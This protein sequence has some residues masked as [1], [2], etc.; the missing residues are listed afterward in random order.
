MRGGLQP[1]HR[2]VKD[3]GG[4]ASLIWTGA[5]PAL[6]ILFLTVAFLPHF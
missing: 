6:T 1:Q 4:A 2:G 5:G 3:P